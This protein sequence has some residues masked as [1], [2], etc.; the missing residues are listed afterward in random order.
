MLGSRWLPPAG[1]GRFPYS[2]RERDRPEGEPAVSIRG[3]GAV[4][5]G[6]SVWCWEAP[7]VGKLP[8]SNAG[9]GWA[10][11]GF[12]GCSSSPPQ[13]PGAHLIS[14]WGILALSGS[15]PCS[16]PLG[17]PAAHKPPG[18][19]ALVRPGLPSDEGSAV[20]EGSDLACPGMGLGG[21]QL[22]QDHGCRTGELGPAAGRAPFLP[23]S[24]QSTAETAPEPRVEVVFFSQ[25]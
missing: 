9:G 19:Q 16:W 18:P 15:G 5:G 4:N 13:P 17:F 3:P 22:L 10:D 7:D 11:C 21:R 12:R 25:T 23:A 20:G 8:L 24:C 14:A 1:L 6:G 2:S